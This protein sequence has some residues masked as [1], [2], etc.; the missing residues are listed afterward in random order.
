MAFHAWLQQLVQVQLTAPASV[1]VRLVQDLAVGVDPDGADA[2]SWQ[3]LLAD[4]FSIGAPPDEFQADGQSWGLPPWIPWRLRA[5]GLPPAGRPP[6]VPRWSPAAGSGSTTSWASPACSGCPRAA[7]PATAPTCAS[8]A[9]SSWRSWPSRAP[10]AAPSSS[11][12]TSAPSRPASASELQQRRILST[13]VVWFEDAPPEHVAGASLGDGHH[14]R[15]PHPR[16]DGL[17]IGR[18]TGMRAHLERLVGPLETQPA[19][20]VAV[21]VHRRLGESP[22]VLALATLEDLLGV[23]DRPNVPGTTDDDRPNWSQALPV[24][25]EDLPEHAGAVRILDALSEGR[26]I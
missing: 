21:A 25:L 10:A 12:R 14:A 11:A 1:G 8:P 6:R 22:S 18:A 2:W 9:T 16:R 5:A 13:K 20:E 26:Q 19:D 17:W 4:E 7:T 24:P 23:T 15:P 3:D